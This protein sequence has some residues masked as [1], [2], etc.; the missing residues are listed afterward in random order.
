M[1]TLFLQSELNNVVKLIVQDYGLLGIIR[2]SFPYVE[3]H[4]STQMTTHNS[5]QIEFLSKLGAKQVNYSRELSL[6]EIKQLNEVTHKLGLKSDSMDIQ[7]IKV[8]AYNHVDVFFQG[9]Q[10]NH[11]FHLT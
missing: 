9:I 6:N 8:D 10:V 7:E 3:V 11:L 2:D 4:S 1:N 5:L